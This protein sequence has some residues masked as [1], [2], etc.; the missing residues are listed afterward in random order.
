MSDQ[1]KSARSNLSI[2]LKL[3]GISVIGLPFSFGLCVLFMWSRGGTEVLAWVG[4]GLFGLSILG[5]VVSVLWIAG[6]AIIGLF[7]RLST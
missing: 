1:P 5:I 6:V 2:P 4:V 7:R 3:M